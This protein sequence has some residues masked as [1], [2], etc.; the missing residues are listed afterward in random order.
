MGLKR[1]SEMS[2]GL[3]QDFMDVYKILRLTN[4]RAEVVYSL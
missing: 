1:G 2:R 3:I 4:I